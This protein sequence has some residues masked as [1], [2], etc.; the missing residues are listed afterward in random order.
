VLR[1]GEFSSRDDLV[2]KM[3]AFIDHHSTTAKPF[4]WV[5]DAKVAA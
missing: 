2:A 5:Y 3:M 1:R 4:K